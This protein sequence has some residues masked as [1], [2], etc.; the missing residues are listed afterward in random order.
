MSPN[1]SPPFTG[2]AGGGSS[3]LPLWEGQGGG[4]SSSPRFLFQP[5]S[6]TSTFGLQIIP[7]LRPTDELWIAEGPSDLLAMASA[8]H[9]GIAIASA[10]LIRPEDFLPL[11]ERGILRWRMVHDNDSAG[12]QARDRIIQL[13]NQLGAS[14]IA[15]PPPAPC[16]D[17]GEWWA[18]EN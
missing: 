7:Y 3:S 1:L 2:G 15:T 6:R 13:A 14:I 11:K 12:L 5:G 17:F 18:K 9:R 16:K 10:T 4:S 8:G